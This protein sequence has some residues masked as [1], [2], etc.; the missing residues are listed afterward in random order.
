MSGAVH[1]RVEVHRI[2]LWNDFG[3][4][5]YAVLSVYYMVTTSNNRKKS[6]MGV[7]TDWYVAVKH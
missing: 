3:F 1:I 4:S 7:S 6:K 2:N 5:L